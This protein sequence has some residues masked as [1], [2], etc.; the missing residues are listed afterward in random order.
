[1]EFLLAAAWCLW[2]TTWL[3]VSVAAQ[4]SDKVGDRLPA[5]EPSA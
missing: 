4:F 5:R 1:M 3:S 2:L